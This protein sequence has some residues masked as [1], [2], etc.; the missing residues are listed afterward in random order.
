[1]STVQQSNVVGN[2]QR[3]RVVPKEKLLETKFQNEMKKY[4]FEPVTDLSNK[5]GEKFFQQMSTSY[6]EYLKRHG[7]ASRINFSKSMYLKI[8]SDNEYDIK[9]NKLS[10]NEIKFISP[11]ERL[12]FRYFNVYYQD[13]YIASLSLA[14]TYGDRY[15]YQLSINL[16]ENKD[17]LYFIFYF[18][19]KIFND[20][21]SIAQR[22]FP[23]IYYYGVPPPDKSFFTR[24]SF[25][26]IEL[27][28]SATRNVFRINNDKEP[29]KN[30]H[31][32]SLIEYYW[33]KIKTRYYSSKVF[34]EM[35]MEREKFAVKKNVQE[36][37]RDPSYKKKLDRNIPVGIY[38]Q[39]LN[40]I[41]DSINTIQQLQ[42]VLTEESL[43]KKKKI[44]QHQ[45]QLDSIYDVFSMQDVPM[46][47]FLKQPDTIVLINE[48]GQHFGHYLTTH[49]I[50]YECEDD[51]S[52]PSYVNNP[53]VN[54]MIRMATGDGGTYYFLRTD[55]IIKDMQEGY[56][57]FHFKTNPQ[58]VKVLSKDVAT[59]GE[60]VSGLHCDKKDLVKISE[61]TNKEK[62]GDGLQMTGSIEF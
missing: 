31:D 24:R 43:E 39:Y 30:I 2:Q 42:K 62:R 56:N 44:Q 11:W 36:F 49:E 19:I 51:R 7:L 59:G 16:K 46:D 27:E 35:I 28:D 4:N 22:I 5:E 1:M 17:K 58:D 38:K 37:K 34:L 14:L 55:P 26:P 21:E 8:L 40:K 60:I 23:D 3:T 33:G 52:Y 18:V 25:G 47:K 15:I 13:I 10:K 50:I 6:E 9:N 41:D 53:N 12:S 57:V 32:D 54:A 45:K 48:K 61:T 20:D 29:H